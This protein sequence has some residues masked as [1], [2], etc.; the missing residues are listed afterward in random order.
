[1]IKK[2]LLWRIACLWALCLSFSFLQANESC[3]YKQN[4]HFF[5]L[6]SASP[7]KQIEIHY[8]FSFQCPGCAKLYPLLEPYFHENVTVPVY[9]HPLASN[10]ATMQL[11]KAYEIIKNNHYSQHYVR[12]LYQ[13]PHK[14]KMS[15]KDIIKLMKDAGY[16]NFEVYWNSAN[17]TLI[18]NNISETL[19]L[20]RTLRLT[21]LPVIYI[22]GP[23][24]VYYIY[25]NADLGL[26]N[27]PDCIE[28]VISFQKK[29]LLE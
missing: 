13:T 16:Q 1:M 23:K 20:A 7:Q 12:A 19:K 27:I 9:Y 29:A 3:E 14:T 24:G 4:Y 25:P 2:A 18:Q 5:K 28:T 11:I 22:M 10:Q 15:Q 26:E 21:S 17:N 8:F 6:G